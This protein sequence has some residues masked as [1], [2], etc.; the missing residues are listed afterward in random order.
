MDIDPTIPPSDAAGTDDALRV[1]SAHDRPRWMVIA[2][3]T[4]IG[5]VVAA[6]YVAIAFWS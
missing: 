6:G 2:L 4:P 1:T 5:F 3:F